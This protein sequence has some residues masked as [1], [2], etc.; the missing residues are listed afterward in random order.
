MRK[1]ICLLWVLVLSVFFMMV[2]LHAQETNTPDTDGLE[3]MAAYFPEVDF[4]AA[5]YTDSAYLDVLDDALFGVTSKLPQDIS[6]AFT[7]RDFLN[8]TLFAGS[9]LNLI[10]VVEAWLGAYAAVGISGIDVLLDDDLNND[11]EITLYI[12]AQISNRFL[13]T[14][15]LAVLGWT[16]DAEQD[17]QGQFT[18]FT[19]PERTFAISDDLLLV[20]IG[21]DDLFSE[22]M[23]TLADN[24]MFTR[25][26]GELEAQDYDAIVYEGR[27]VVLQTLG[28][29]AGLAEALAALKL[30][31]DVLGPVVAGF[32]ITEDETVIFDVAQLRPSAT[33]AS[34][35]PVDI[36]FASFVPETSVF[37][38][39]TTDLNTLIGT[40][41]GL[42]ASISASDTQN[43]IY[44]QFENL[45]ELLL[46][47]NLQQDILTWTNEDYGFVI[48]GDAQNAVEAPVEFGVLFEIANGFD[49]QAETLEAA[50]GETIARIFPEDAVVS[51]SELVIRDKSIDVISIVTALE[52]AEPRELILASDGRLF[53][54]ATT[55]MAIELLS[56]N[57]RLVDNAVYEDAI[58]H[59]LR[60]P[61]FVVFADGRSPAQ[62]LPFLTELLEPLVGLIFTNAETDS[63]EIFGDIPQA[64]SNVVRSASISAFTNENQSLM[65]R[66]AVT[67]P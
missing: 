64:I 59:L 36:N 49:T 63:E 27:S 16:V 10:T 25:A 42:I 2:P 22:S 43:D 30:D 58:T 3:A 44:E 40:A 15:S 23:R 66:F 53:F 47:L 5:A 37:F 45:S 19:S 32:A 48:Q 31:V 34:T 1:A 13:A 51:P 38:V 11:D 39:Q 46:G 54:M 52:S 60:R 57:T 14:S 4:F 41:S 35:Q 8:Q 50:L 65:L 17:T 12:A 56:Q 29:D 67:L 62:L 55:Q 20:T 6:P 18:T 24:P 33:F 7:L 9:D 21:G 28:E 61:D 26:L